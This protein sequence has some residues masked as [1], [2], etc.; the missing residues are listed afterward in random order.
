MVEIKAGQIQVLSAT[1]RLFED[2]TE[3][4]NKAELEV[5]GETVESIKLCFKDEE[6][7]SDTLQIVQKFNISLKIK[8]TVE[9]EK[10][11]FYL[12]PKYCWT[13]KQMKEEIIERGIAPCQV[14][15]LDSKNPTLIINKKVPKRKGQELKLK[16]AYNKAI[17]VIKKIIGKEEM[18]KII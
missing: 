9:G 11:F 5:Y 4:V 14:I 7:L 16:L 12:T 1:N 8:I 17:N 3:K 10:E 6:T 18:L 13:N 15:L 2:I